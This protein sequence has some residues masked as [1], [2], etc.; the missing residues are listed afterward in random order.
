MILK[1]AVKEKG[2]SALEAELKT[3][4]VSREREGRG[5]VGWGVQGAHQL[6]HY[7][8]SSRCFISHE[9][10]FT[11]LWLPFSF[12]VTS[13]PGHPPPPEQLPPTPA[14]SHTGL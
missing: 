11:P 8:I 5:G 7:P 10:T 1:M 14:S 6:P 4:E 3:A 12:P 9:N 2:V 13:G